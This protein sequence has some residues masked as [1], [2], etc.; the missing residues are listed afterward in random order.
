MRILLVDDEQIALASVKRIL[1]HRGMR[2]VDI[3]DNGKDA[4]L[5]IKENDYDIVFLDMLMPEVD[6]LEVLETAKPFRP[7]TEFIM[8]TA[9]DDIAN[10]VKAIRLGAY[11]YLIKPVEN[12]RLFLSIE[13]AYERRAMRTGMAGMS[14][15]SGKGK[16]SEAFSEIICQCSRMQEV[17]HY[18]EMMAKTESPVLITGESGTGKELMARGIHQASQKAQ[19]PFIPVNVCS[20]A[21]SMFESQFFGHVQGAFTGA[22]RD[23]PGFFEQAQ[24]GTLFLDEIGELPMN[25]QAKFLRVLEE[26]T[27]TR[28]GDPK[29]VNVDVRI[30]SATN[31]DID[32]ACQEGKFRLDLMYRLKAVHIHLPPL[33]ERT[34]DI[35][36][37][38]IHFLEKGCMNHQKEIKGFSPD[39]MDILCRKE[40]PGNARELAQLVDS[41]VLIADSDFVQPHHLG[42]KKAPTA[43]IGQDLCSFKENSEKHLL[44]ILSQTNGDRNQAAEILGVTLRQV[45][46]KLAE[47]KKNPRWSSFLG[48]L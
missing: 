34:G 10:S 36:L 17:L 31:V 9:V 15:F 3:C 33:R 44:Y 18:A 47:M 6:G 28:L 42:E 7:H 19:G 40:F 5:L 37:L 25:L 24:G 11:D 16:V 35:P 4:I 32:K 27:I 22:T 1:K 38:A 39:A 43:T 20:V 23:Y 2:D 14:A 12:D 13:R 48:D 45:Q 41:A 26:K 8:L 30:L 21:D 46:R 29:P